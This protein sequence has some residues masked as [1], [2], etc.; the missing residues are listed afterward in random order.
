MDFSGFSDISPAFSNLFGKIAS[1]P[2]LSPTTRA[3]LLG[4]YMT[5]VGQIEEQRAKISER[6]ADQ[7]LR[8]LRLQSAQE[9]L[10]EARRRRKLDEQQ[11]LRADEVQSSV[12]QIVGSS[13]PPEQQA[14]E[15]GRLAVASNAYSN[16]LAMGAIDT[17][18]RALPAPPKP[19]EN[20]IVSDYATAF[21]N[22]EYATDV[23]GAPVPDKLTDK[24]RNEITAFYIKYNPDFARQ[25]DELSDLDLLQKFKQDMPSASGTDVTALFD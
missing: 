4:E 16:P 15:L 10:S 20:K 3:S 5:S 17:A 2:R 6:R 18:M 21:K 12:K 19:V 1:D 11:Q 13:L 14:A 8:Y 24:S 22:V 23:R 25:I 9:S 7:Q